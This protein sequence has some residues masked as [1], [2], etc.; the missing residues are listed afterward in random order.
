MNN[1]NNLKRNFS[2]QYRY[3]VQGCIFTIEKT[4]S[5]TWVMTGYES[6][7]DEQEYNEFEEWTDTK[8][9][10]LTHFLKFTFDKQAW[11]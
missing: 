8:K 6:V 11:L 9:G 7:S 5:G 1:V 4:M 3:E 10:N 2:F